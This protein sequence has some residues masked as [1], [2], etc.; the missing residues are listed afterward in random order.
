MKNN[1]RYPIG[2][3]TSDLM[4]DLHRVVRACEQGRLGAAEQM[5]KKVL[6]QSPNLPQALHLMGVISFRQ[7][8]PDQAVKYLR[9]AVA[10]EPAYS[11]ALNDLG[12]ILHELGRIDEAIATFRRL[13]ELEPDQPMALNN[14]AVILKDKGEVREAISLLLHAI[15]LDPIHIP[16]LLNLAYAYIKQDALDCAIDAFQR[17]SQIDPLNV[18]PLRV[19]A[20]TYRVVGD[21]EK[22]VE[23]YRRWLAIEPDCEIAK[24]MLSAYSPGQSPPRATEDFVRE[25]FNQF[26]ESFDKK[27]ALLKYRGPELVLEQV[28]SRYR[29]PSGSLDILDAGCGTGLVGVQLRPFARTLTGVDLSG[30]M[31][32]QARRRGVYD[33]L[34]EGD[35]C[36]YVEQK[37]AAFDLVTVIETL[38]YFGELSNPLRLLASS[39]RPGGALAF[40]LEAATDPTIDF[41]LTR[42]GRYVHGQAYVESTVAAAGFGSFETFAVELREE[43][44]VVVNGL[45]VWAGR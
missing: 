4:S 22:T 10:Q 17:V 40:T 3:Q 42:S 37:H 45:L 28:A 12:N 39:I 29:A 31:L 24:H 18:E 14:L 23:T 20:H 30:G 41:L 21:D 27:L 5:C 8:A 32:A 35:L 9:D 15:H 25:E 34:I 11:L 6:G 36:A 13:L 7:G 19:L 16:S 43:K 33:E 2:K 44:G 26:A 38:I 1:R